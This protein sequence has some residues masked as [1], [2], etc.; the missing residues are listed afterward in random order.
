MDRV[1]H[2]AR[3]GEDLVQRVRQVLTQ[4]TTVRPLG[5]RR[6]PVGCAVG[7]RWRPVTRAH[8]H[9]RRL[10]APRCYGRGRALGAQ[11]HRLA[12]LE[13]HAPRAR[14]LACPPRTIVAAE[15][16]GSGPRRDRQP[17]EHAQAGATAAGH[18]QAPAERYA[19]GATPGAGEVR[20]PVEAALGP[21]GPGGHDT[22]PPLRTHAAHPAPIGAAKRPDAALPPH[23][24]VGP[25]EI[26][27]G[28]LSA[29]MDVPRRHVTPGTG[30]Q[31]RRGRH[32]P[33]Q[34]RG[35]GVDV[36]CLQVP[37]G[38]LRAHRREAC[39]P[40]LGMP[41]RG[42]IGWSPGS[43]PPGYL[44]TRGGGRDGNASPTAPKSPTLAQALAAHR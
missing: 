18:A 20:Q 43:F 41:T 42:V 37:Q 14:R 28:P 16:R 23:A 25:R 7:G 6:R 4:R 32:A 24:G 30:P 2:L 38:R 26:S 35:G 9:P 40:P 29:T 5:R 27:D 36:P 19:R 34:R 31:R 8:L 17:A 13:S 21:P 39:H 11:R 3:R 10:P 15:D 22:R 44:R 33:A 1:E 12:A